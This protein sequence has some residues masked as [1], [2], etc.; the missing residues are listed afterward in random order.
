[1]SLRQHRHA[2]YRLIGLRKIGK[3]IMDAPS[4]DHYINRMYVMSYI[5]NTINFAK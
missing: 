1:M 2:T 5:L 3:P 4:F